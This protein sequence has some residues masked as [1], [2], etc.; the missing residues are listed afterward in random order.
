MNTANHSPSHPEDFRV[1]WGPEGTY[2]S[3][4]ISLR[5]FSAGSVL[6]K[7][8]LE[9]QPTVKKAYT[10]V[11]FRDSSTGSEPS[12]I[13]LCS[14]L[15]FINHSCSPNV[16]FELPEGLQGRQNGSWVLR[17][18]RDVKKGEELTFAYFSTEWDMA[19]PFDC[20]CGATECLGRIRGARY[21]PTSI[22]K[23]YFVNDYILQLKK[24]T[25]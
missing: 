20:R 14:D 11:Q 8:G 6:A 15:V 24:S 17:A 1:E 9:T 25:E 23:K 18:L 5:D 7:L 10:S 16:A 4:L 13:E 12:H 19:Q 21:L 3:S 22:L 2:R